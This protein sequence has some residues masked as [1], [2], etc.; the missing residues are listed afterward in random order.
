MVVGEATQRD[1]S[2]A[3]DSLAAKGMVAI[4]RVSCV[5][6][7]SGLRLRGKGLP[8]PTTGALFLRLCD[9]QTTMRVLLIAHTKVVATIPGYQPHASADA[10]TDID[11]LMEQAGRLCYESWER[12]NPATATNQ[13]YAANIL[14]QQHYSV[15][16]H[17]TASFYIDGVTRNLTHELIRHRHFS[18]SEVSQRYV[19]VGDFP[20][21]RHPG[22]EVTGDN[23][24]AVLLEADRAT[25]KAYKAIVAELVGQGFPRKA[26]R[27][28]A[29][30]ALMSG[31]ETKM[32]VSGNMNAWRTML[33][34]RL[35]PKA[36]E[37]FRR[38]AALILGDLKKIAPNTFQDF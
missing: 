28:T 12:P 8:S 4:P 33:P 18:F 11:D 32:L 14:A 34:K 23:I 24:D 31:T 7:E 15:T 36:D 21:I 22:F 35:S 9:Y 37:E 38:V 16:E 19:D 5:P 2:W 3:G 27:Q 29:R 1:T 26:A 30:H 17:G 13:G 25:R 10:P 20:F 6:G